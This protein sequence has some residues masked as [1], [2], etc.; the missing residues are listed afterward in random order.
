VPN[1]LLARG[2]EARGNAVYRYRFEWEAPEKRACH[3]MDLPF[4]F[5]TFDVSTWCE[6]SGATG[7]RRAAA[8]AL[9]TQM[10]EAWTS[11]AATGT[12]SD[13]VVGAWPAPGRTCLGSEEPQQFHDT[14]AHRTG[15]WLG[16]T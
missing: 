15:I 5:G 8:D 11:F 9:S 13:S 12:P 3:A 1:E 14:I 2:H 10:R 7:P 16:D 6:F 4:T